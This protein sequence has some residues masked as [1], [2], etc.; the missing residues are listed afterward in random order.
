MTRVDLPSLA[1]ASQSE[2]ARQMQ[3]C[4]ACRY[5]EGLC[6]VFP[7]MERRRVFTEGDV[8]YLAN[9]CHNCGACHYD[10]QY[11]PPHPFAV[12]VPQAM[13]ELREESYARF[14]WPQALGPVFARNGVWI[15]L[16]SALAVAGFI[17]GFALLADPGAL[18]ASGDF[19]AVMPH[20]AMVAVFAPVFLFSLLALA[21]SL[22]RF[23]RTADDAHP[24]PV[25]LAALWQAM[26]E[27]AALRY[28]DGGGMGCMSQSE[29]PDRH[30]RT[31]HHLTFYGF[32]LCFASTSSGT[33]MHYLLDWP[34]PYPWWAPPKL[35]GVP[36]GLGLVIGAAGL[37]W[38]DWRR[39]PALLP[40]RRTGMGAAF[41]WTLL[42]LGATG[43]ALYWLRETPAMG[44]LLAVHLG[45]VFAFFVTMPYGKFVHG[46]YRFAALV[47]HAHEGRA[48]DVQEAEAPTEGRV[49]T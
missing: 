35:L 20:D 48:H 32:L 1:T 19:Y 34:A 4:N 30:R 16:V 3:V 44:V 45:V 23:W 40:E 46:L 25:T 11:A 29:R 27:A 43:L 21:L 18:T 49:R 42:A 41:T 10:C 15:A 24:V 31:F 9:L 6:A 36:G 28:F 37:I 47:R 5:C 39:D 14:A 12:N 17:L 26:R 2:V 7:A 38:Y 13:A 8:D 33:L 22:R